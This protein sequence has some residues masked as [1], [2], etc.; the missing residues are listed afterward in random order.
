[1]ETGTPLTDADERVM[2]HRMVIG[3]LIGWVLSIGAILI[4]AW[5]AVGDRGSAYIWGAAVF[6]GIVA[7]LFFGGAGGV[8]Y[9][10]IQLEAEGR[11]H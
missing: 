10:Q 3:I 8:M 6:A 2:F 4:A 5:I 11:G 7:G 9:H 1:M